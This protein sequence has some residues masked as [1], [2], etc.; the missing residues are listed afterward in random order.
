M[1][2]KTAMRVLLVS[3]THLGFDLPV[4]PRVERTSFAERD[5]TKGFVMATL[6]SRRFRSRWTLSHSAKGSGANT[7]SPSARSIT[8]TPARTSVASWPAVQPAQPV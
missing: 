4:R 6:A 3:D 8:Q 1:G 7:E 5:E 2:V